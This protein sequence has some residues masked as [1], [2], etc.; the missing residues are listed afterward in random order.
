MNTP[1][2]SKD[3]GVM[4]NAPAI[5]PESSIP[6]AIACAPGIE[7]CIKWPFAKT[8]DCSEKDGRDIKSAVTAPLEF[9]A[10]AITSPI[11][12]W[13]GIDVRVPPE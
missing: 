8:N 1:A 6:P 5:T 10:R 3:S 11:S 12:G 4:P 9:I 13:F 7:S 2:V